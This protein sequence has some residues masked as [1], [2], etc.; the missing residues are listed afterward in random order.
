MRQESEFNPAAISVVKA[1]GLMQVM[2]PT[3]RELGRRV[4]LGVVRPNSLKI[5]DINLNIGTYYL[6]HQLAAR[7]GSVEDT[8]AGYNAG[9]SRVPV[10]RTWW[11]FREPSEFVETIPFTQTREYVQIVMRN[12]EMY[13]RIYAN[14]PYTAEPEPP[15]TPATI[16][17]APPARKT[18]KAPVKAA[19]RKSTRSTSKK[20]KPSATRTSN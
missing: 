13:R 8:L 10:W 6:Q 12:A 3:G 9:P 20:G 17:S 15:E 16:T 18:A 14:E 4:G 19:A 5:P 2:P 1:I 7:N 11:D